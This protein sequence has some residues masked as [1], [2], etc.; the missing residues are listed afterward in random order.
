MKSEK[1]HRVSWN[2]LPAK[3]IVC[4][5]CLYYSFEQLEES[6][7]LT[8]DEMLP[9]IK[10]DFKYVYCVHQ[11]LVVWPAPN[12]VIPQ[13]GHL[14]VHFGFDF[15]Q[16]VTWHHQRLYDHVAAVYISR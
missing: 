10:D 8:K 16:R 13:D 15:A 2:L 7:C 14:L 6:K 9:L 4:R 1:G 5:R 12:L 3:N 11:K